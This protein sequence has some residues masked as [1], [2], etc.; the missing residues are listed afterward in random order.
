MSKKNDLFKIILG[1][2]IPMLALW[3]FEFRETPSKQQPREY[4]YACPRDNS[5]RCYE[6]EANVDREERRF[7]MVDNIYF[8]DGGKISFWDCLEGEGNKVFCYTRDNS[9]E[10]DIEPTGRKTVTKY[11]D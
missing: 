6:L 5:V 8:P 4:V 1:F 9:E 3:Y 2:G 11:L 10:W 7:P